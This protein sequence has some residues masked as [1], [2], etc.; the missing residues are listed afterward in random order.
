M[1]GQVVRAEGDVAVVCIGSKDRVQL[2]AEFDAYEFRYQG[3][4]SEGTDNYSRHKVG[5]V[6]ITEI[7]DAHF[8]RAKIVSGKVESRNMVELGRD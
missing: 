5:V 8:A 6:R 4:I 1:R 7:I 3:A 2:G